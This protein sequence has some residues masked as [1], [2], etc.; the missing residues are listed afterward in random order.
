MYNGLFRAL[1]AL[2]QRSPERLQYFTLSITHLQVLFA[3]AATTSIV[4][5]LWWIHT[6]GLRFES[7]R[8]RIGNAH[9]KM[10]S[11]KRQRKQE[12]CNGVE[13]CYN[14]SKMDSESIGR[15]RRNMVKLKWI[16][17]KGHVLLVCTAL[18]LA[19]GMGTV[20]ESPENCRNSG[21]ICSLV[22]CQ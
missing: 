13:N 12:K 22:L 17:S 8:T 16:N 19:R 5:H 6:M 20:H 14:T 18:R 21:N 1:S 3:M 2:I 7:C 11:L 9:K 10:C 4:E 15:S